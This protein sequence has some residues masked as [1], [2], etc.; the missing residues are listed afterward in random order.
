MTLDDFLKTQGVVEGSPFR[1][2]KFSPLVRVV[3]VLCTSFGDIVLSWLFIHVAE[4]ALNFFDR[5]FLVSRNCPGRHAVARRLLK[6]DVF[7]AGILAD[8]FP[9]LV[10]P[11]PAKRTFAVRGENKIVGLFALNVVHKIIP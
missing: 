3:I 9:D 6:M 8:L 5:L 10:E 7:L 1:R 4:L 2:G 11:T